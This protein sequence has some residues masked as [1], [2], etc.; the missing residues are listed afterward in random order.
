MNNTFVFFLLFITSSLAAQ[1]SYDSLSVG[2]VQMA[3]PVHDGKIYYAGGLDGFEHSN[4]IEIL[5]TDERSWE[6][7]TLS[8]PRSFPSSVVLNDKMYF[9]GGIDYFTYDELPII[10]VLDLNT[11]EWTTMEMPTATLRGAIVMQN[12]IVLSDGFDIESTGVVGRYP[13]YE[14]YNPADSSWARVGVPRIC[15]YDCGFALTED[16]IYVFGG[17]TVGEEGLTDEINIFDINTL[18][19]TTAQLPEPLG[20]KTSINI[21]GKAYLFGVQNADGFTLESMIYDLATGEITYGELDLVRE[22]SRIGVLGTK[23]YF[24]GGG[25]LDE[26]ANVFTNAVNQIDIYDTATD[27]WTYDE[28]QE[29]R[30]NHSVTTVGNS[31]YVAGGYDFVDIINSI[32]IFTDPSVTDL[33]NVTASASA[34]QVYPNPVRDQLQVDLPSSTD[35]FQLELFDSA[36]KLLLSQQ[37]ERSETAAL[38]LPEL[39]KG[40]YFLRLSSAEGTYRA[41]VAKL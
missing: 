9:I 35:N 20:F 16:K 27:E 21:D 1:W 24:I 6:Y 31:I 3:A 18:Q 30:I 14:I 25:D 15:D 41:T 40:T 36:G 37:V 13:N 26:V 32:E 11:R 10:D 39:A 2:R 5:D 22:G 8:I 38:S 17:R 23:I 34:L 7:D 4:L 28:L 19:W 29:A 12:K 33:E